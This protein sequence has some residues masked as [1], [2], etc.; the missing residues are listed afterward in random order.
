MLV[1]QLLNFSNRAIGIINFKKFFFSKFSRRNYELLSKF[2]VGLK[3]LLQQGL[4][5]PAFYCD[6]VYKIKNIVSR[7]YC[8]GQFRKLSYIPNVLGVIQM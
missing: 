3:T 4:T 2:K 5:E 7:A 8:S 6:L 1:F